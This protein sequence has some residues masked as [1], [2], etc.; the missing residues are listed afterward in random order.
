MH[1]FRSLRLVCAE[2][3]CSPENERCLS[4]QLSHWPFRGGWKASRSRGLN[5]YASRCSQRHN[6]E[7]PGFPGNFEAKT[8]SSSLPA[9]SNFVWKRVLQKPRN[10][11]L[12]ITATF[13]ISLSTGKIHKKESW[14]SCISTLFKLLYA[15]LL[16]QPMYSRHKIWIGATD[17]ARKFRFFTFLFFYT[18]FLRV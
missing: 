15:M 7:L 17:A 1:R 10:Q 16:L 11:L 2:S 18:N 8:M 13:L 12:G 5:P 6:C 14:F 4:V 3:T 9:T